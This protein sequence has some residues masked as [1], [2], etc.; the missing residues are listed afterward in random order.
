MNPYATLEVPSDA[1]P[2]AVRKAFRKKAGQTH[3][4]RNNG[5]DA[6]FKQVREAYAILA[7]PGRRKRFDETGETEEPARPPAALSLLAQCFAEAAM[8]T[9]K[10]GASARSRDMAAAVR[11]KL[12][13]KKAGLEQERDPLL[14]A[15][16]FMQEA[17][18]RFEAKDGDN[19]LA[20][21][22][23]GHLADVEKGLAEIAGK[24]AVV[25]EALA[26]AARHTFRF[27]RPPES[28]DVFRGF[29]PG[30][31]WSN[32]GPPIRK[33]GGGFKPIDQGEEQ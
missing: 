24:L 13:G 14:R 10:A 19:V 31:A 21:I 11:S 29:G 32:W 1:S 6:E 18:A 17:A 33:D 5:E 7:D 25:E 27:E 30:T 4:D 12:Q 2:E 23:R 16:L 28:N 20:G 26:I 3:P 15:R 9:I 8:E 22:A